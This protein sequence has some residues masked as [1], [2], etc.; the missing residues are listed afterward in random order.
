MKRKAMMGILL[1]V[2]LLVSGV[3]NSMEF[4]VGPMAF[5]FLVNFRTEIDY[6]GG[7]DFRIYG[8]TT[9]STNVNKIEARITLQRWNGAFWENVISFSQVNHNSSKAELTRFVNVPKGFTYRVM[10][11]HIVYHTVNEAAITFTPSV[12]AH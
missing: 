4:G 1:L 3:S 9:A 6:W 7:G 12:Y 5:D 10:G 8:V 2:V 11:D